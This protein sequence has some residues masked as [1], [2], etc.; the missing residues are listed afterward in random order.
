[1][2]SSLPPDIPR[3]SLIL[4]ISSI[5]FRSARARLTLQSRRRP[6][7]ETCCCFRTTNRR[8][9]SQVSRVQAGAGIEGDGDDKEGGKSRQFFKQRQTLKLSSPPYSLSLDNSSSTRSRTPTMLFEQE[10]AAP[11]VRCTI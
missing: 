2:V 10:K 3:Y 4:T 11:E 8:I 5:S 7:A 6:C 1:M 9:A